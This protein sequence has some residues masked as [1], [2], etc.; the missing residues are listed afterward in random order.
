MKYNL[1]NRDIQGKSL[2]DVV[3]ENRGI[4]KSLVDELLVAGKEDYLNPFEIYGMNDAIEQFKEEIAKENNILICV[5]SD[6][7]GNC[8]AAIFYKF[9]VEDIGYDEEKMFY[10][11]HSGKQHGITKELLEHIKEIDAKYLIV[12]DAGTN[13]LVEM[14]K[15]NKHDVKILVLDHHI[16]EIDL[17]DIPSNTV[18]VNNQINEVSKYGSGTLVTAKFVEAFDYDIM[19]YE[20]LIAASIVADSMD[21]MQM[22]NRAFINEGLN[23]I[24]NPLIKE[25]FKKNKVKKPIINDVS[26]NL[27]NYVNAIVRV[28]T[29]EEKDLMFKAFIGK[30]EEFDYVK[31]GGETTKETLQERVVRLS[32]NAKSR[33]ANSIKKAV[34]ECNKY[35]TR[36]H[37]EHDK[38]IIIKN[39]DEFIDRSITG[40]IAMKV[41]D[42][43]HKPCIIL[44]R[45]NEDYYSGSMRSFGLDSFKD[46]LEETSL[47][48]WIKGHDNAAGV[49]IKVENV[50]KLRVALNEK[51]KDIE[52]VDGKVYQVDSIIDST[53]LN[54]KEMKEIAQLNSLWCSTAR[55]PQFAIKN[56][57]IDSV[58]I[59][60]T[61]KLRCEFKA[62]GVK[63]VKNWCSKD[64]FNMITCKDQLKFGRS[65]PLNITLVCEFNL[66]YYGNPIVEIVDA[67]SVKNTQIIF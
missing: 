9:L 58:K 1:I 45:L 40:L 53:K 33:Q 10:H 60:M 50:E 55:K 38:V 43:N 41:A 63:F 30:V 37:L 13:N 15:L 7:D 14:K 16:C 11:I 21:C 44:N 36:H 59:E 54:K 3:F 65:I 27:A 5:D 19:K 35:I 48:E 64:F 24:Q 28:G 46:V 23:N 62:N 67:N 20:D 6:M 47:M 32:S 56:I 39:D 34:G 29:M 26:Y 42:A 25:Y 2:L 17:N 31:R 57:Q 52:F 49:N 66:D 12:P 51:L 18:I 61:G 4:D 8:S 22:E